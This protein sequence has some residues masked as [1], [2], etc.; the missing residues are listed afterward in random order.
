MKTEKKILCRCSN[1][2]CDNEY[3]AV[4]YTDCIVCNYAME[5]VDDYHELHIE[6]E[7]GE[8]DEY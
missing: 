3:Y 6:N 4:P 2:N 5:P 7:N 1:F 8:E